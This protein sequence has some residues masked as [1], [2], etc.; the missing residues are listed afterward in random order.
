M[1]NFELSEILNDSGLTSSLDAINELANKI[2][3]QTSEYINNTKNQT[4][5][6]RPNSGTSI[7][8]LPVSD[9]TSFFINNSQSEIQNIN[10]GIIPELYSNS[11]WQILMASQTIPMGWLYTST[12]Y[13]DYKYGRL[14]DS[15]NK[16]ILGSKAESPLY[17]HLT[18]FG[19][20]ARTIGGHK[21]SD[22]VFF[23]IYDNQIDYNYL[24]KYFTDN[25]V[26][27]IVLMTEEEYSS[28]LVDGLYYNFLV[29]FD[30]VIN[31]YSGVIFKAKNKL[32]EAVPTYL[33]EIAC[34]NSMA[35]YKDKDNKITDPHI[36]MVEF[37]KGSDVTTTVY[38]PENYVI[39][40]VAVN[41]STYYRNTVEMDAA[42][43][44]IVETDAL[45][46]T[47]Y[48]TY[49]VTASKLLK[50][51]K[52]YIG[53]CEDRSKLE[54]TK[55]MISSASTLT[56]TTE[57]MTINLVFTRPFIYLDASKIKVWARKT[58]DQGET[59]I[60][61]VSIIMNGHSYVE[62]KAVFRDHDFPYGK[63][64]S[65]NKVPFWCGPCE[66]EERHNDCPTLDPLETDRTLFV[67]ER[68]S[69][70]YVH[71]SC[72][73]DHPKFNNEPKL[74]SHSIMYGVSECGSV[75]LTFD[76]YSHY[77]FFRV[78]IEP[79]A[80][81]ATVK[82]PG[83]PDFD[84]IP[85]IENVKFTNKYWDKLVDDDDED[86]VNN[87]GKSDNNTKPDIVLGSN[88]GISYDD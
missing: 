57:D 23:A 19:L 7:V 4:T 46:L 80:M 39:Y 83:M 8:N 50:D 37:K 10:D 79:G 53:A 66:P 71:Y 25:E 33:L 18:A 88:F 52:L 73:H 9:K 55:A 40:M 63:P 1:V 28:K 81:I 59:L 34:S 84:I 76:G 49:N 22:L 75:I 11:I 86:G 62:R 74:V 27:N 72:P 14:F 21:N 35:I 41:G 58:E 54:T 64:D 78:E 85:Y 5:G 38:L 82:T 61:N 6:I 44:T 2:S 45:S 47:G 15:W 36:D 48:K 77:Q 26:D 70:P 20:V 32:I 60:T 17:I 13:A 65:S 56:A 67:K 29:R 30:K 42:G 68:Y 87:D 16:I 69:N 43:I 12:N 3:L 24:Q 31:P 51:T